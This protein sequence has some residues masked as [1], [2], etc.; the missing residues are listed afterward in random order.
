MVGGSRMFPFY[1]GKSLGIVEQNIMSIKQELKREQIPLVG[2][3]VSD[4]YGRSAEFHL[5]SPSGMV[6]T[7]R[8]Q[9]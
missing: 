9:A 1:N 7:T 2:S 6:E 3:D 8:L 5:V 4:Y